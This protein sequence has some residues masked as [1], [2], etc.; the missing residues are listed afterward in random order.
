MTSSSSSFYIFLIASPM[1]PFYLSFWRH[2]I[3]HPLGSELNKY[4]SVSRQ[5]SMSQVGGILVPGSSFW[6]K[7]GL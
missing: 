2:F 6:I 5:G 1:C 4:E 7:G 3:G